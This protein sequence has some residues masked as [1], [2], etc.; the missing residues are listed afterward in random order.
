M[1]DTAQD[2]AALRHRLRA[3]ALALPEAYEDF[4]WG[5]R[6]IKVNKKI[7]LFLGS[8]EI[9]EKSGF[10]LKLVEAH[11]QALAVPGA[12]PSGYG[13]GRSGWVSVPLGAELPPE[14]VVTDWVEESYRLIA[15]KR[16]VKEL[17][18]RG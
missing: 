12:A 5:E 11:A 17:D 14:E 2:P 16:L 4:P 9:T 6:V 18:A 13:L 10:G 8:D 3:A 15:P 1:P 7:F